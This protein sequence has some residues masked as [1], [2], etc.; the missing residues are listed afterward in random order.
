MF[1]VVEDQ[2]L[3]QSVSALLAGESA[4]ATRPAK[5]R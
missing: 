3:W 1:Y 5:H 4:P 2:A